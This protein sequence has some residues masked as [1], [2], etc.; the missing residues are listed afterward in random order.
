MVRHR[1][2]VGRDTET[3]QI[4]LRRLGEEAIISNGRLAT[5]YKRVF[6][7]PPEAYTKTT[8]RSL[9]TLCSHNVPTLGRRRL[10]YKILCELCDPASL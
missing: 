4:R 2:R 7:Y 9:S 8:L 10:I 3:F 1:H 6:I 5:F